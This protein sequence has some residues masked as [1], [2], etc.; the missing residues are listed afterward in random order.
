[1]ELAK[2]I[3]QGMLEDYSDELI[4]LDKSVSNSRYMRQA[5]EIAGRYGLVVGVPSDMR[6]V[7]P[8][9]LFTVFSALQSWVSEVYTLSPLP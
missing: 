8:H 7:N 5:L 9:E 3:T 1:M 2:E 4:K 6:K